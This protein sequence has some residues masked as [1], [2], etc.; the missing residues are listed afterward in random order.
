METPWSTTQID[1]SL[2][3]TEV[4]AYEPCILFSSKEEVVSRSIV[5]LETF[6]NHHWVVV[7][8]GAGT[9]ALETICNRIGNFTPRV[10]YEVEDFHRSNVLVSEQ[11]GVTMADPSRGSMTGVEVRPFFRAPR[12]RIMCA[13]SSTAAPSIEQHAILAQRLLFRQSVQH[14]SPYYWQYMI[15]HSDHFA[16]VLDAPQDHHLLHADRDPGLPKAS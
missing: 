15:K 11:L 12:F 4:L 14:R 7:G 6:R 16:Q 10:R 13:V 1:P 9:D 8:G 5:D 2:R 3:V